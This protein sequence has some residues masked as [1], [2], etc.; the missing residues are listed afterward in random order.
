MVEGAAASA[1]RFVIFFPTDRS[2]RPADGPTPPVGGPAVEV[3]A[4]GGE[5]GQ[6]W[7]TIDS[8]ARHAARARPPSRRDGVARLGA[9]AGVP[10]QRDPGAGGRDPAAGDRGWSDLGVGGTKGAELPCDGP[11]RAPGKAPGQLTIERPSDRRSP[12]RNPGPQDAFKVLMINVWEEGGAA[13]PLTARRD[14]PAPRQASPLESQPPRFQ[15]RFQALSTGA[16]PPRRRGVFPERLGARAAPPPPVPPGGP[17]G[18]ARVF[19]TLGPGRARV[20]ANEWG[21]L[22]HLHAGLC[23]RGLDPCG[24]R[25][26]GLKTGGSSR[27]SRLGLAHPPCP[28]WREPR[29]PRE[30]RLLLVQAALPPEDGRTFGGGP[31][32]GRHFDSVFPPRVVPG[33][34]GFRLGR[35]FFSALPLPEG[36]GAGEA[37]VRPFRTTGPSRARGLGPPGQ[38]CARARARPCA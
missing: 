11:S 31:S 2:P 3:G 33:G 7:D 34:R 15:E 36:A 25:V 14:S 28:G 29:F 1:H 38:G 13:R 20:P 10:T 21:V 30:H 17:G 27:A 23:L 6:P 8:H 22:P 32:P 5:R 4:R 19:K 26:P 24:S 35:G 12:G 37:H 9:P 18:A 16:S